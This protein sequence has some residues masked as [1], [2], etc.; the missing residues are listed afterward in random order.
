MA[1]TQTRNKTPHYITVSGNNVIQL[2]LVASSYS[3]GLLTALGITKGNEN[4]EV[5]QGKTQIGAGRE[6]ALL[7]GCFPIVVTYDMPGNKKQ[8]A[9]LLCSPSKADTIMAEVKQQTYR[10]RNISK[11]R[12]PRRRVFTF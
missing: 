4:G 6:D 1:A 5:P 7:N 11:A 12:P 3:A 10:G 8:T 2:Q 9:K